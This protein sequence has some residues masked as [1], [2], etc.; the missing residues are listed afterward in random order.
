MISKYLPIR[1]NG[2][3]I[4]RFSIW[5]V[6][7]CHIYLSTNIKN[8]CRRIA[9]RGSRPLT[10]TPTHYLTILFW[11]L[12][13]PVGRSFNSDWFVNVLWTQNYDWTEKKFSQ[14]TI[15]KLF[16]SQSGLIDLPA[17][18]SWKWRHF[19]RV[20]AQVP[21]TPLDPPMLLV[22]LIVAGRFSRTYDAKMVNSVKSK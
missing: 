19:G 10:G 7:K 15:I 22:T 17:G 2:W 9:Q 13:H 14:T 6:Y 11:K 18:C 3:I 12:H 8:L 16:T 1:V 20:G 21:F 4:S 5:K